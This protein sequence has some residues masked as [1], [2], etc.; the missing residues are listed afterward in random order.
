[1]T[2]GSRCGLRVRPLDTCDYSVE[3][4]SFEHLLVSGL[5]DN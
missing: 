2:A 1:M 4:W 5:E 3:V